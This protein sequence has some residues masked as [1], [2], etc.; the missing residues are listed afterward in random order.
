MD[1]AAIIQ[2]YWE[3]DERAIPATDGKYGAYCT[4]IARNILGSR[5]DAEECVSDTY[6]K[7]WESMPPQRPNVL[8]AFLG[9]I[10]RNLSLNR[11]RHN[12]A[13]STFQT[14][15]SQIVSGKG[16][17]KNIPTMPTESR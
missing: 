2:L 3:R 1:D 4:A 9:K 10:V 7:A 13:I 12:T 8:S 6:L 17:I 14:V 16:K 15:V 5:E 11:Y